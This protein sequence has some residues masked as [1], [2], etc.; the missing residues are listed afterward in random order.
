VFVFLI[1]LHQLRI[2]KTPQLFHSPNKQRRVFTTL[3]V[4]HM[5]CLCMAPKIK[6]KYMKKKIKYMVETR[7]HCVNRGINACTA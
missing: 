6:T 3:T 7:K 1:D 4:V 5:H 2:I